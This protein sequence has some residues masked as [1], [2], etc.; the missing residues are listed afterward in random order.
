MSLAFEE[1]KLL[2]LQD[3]WDESQESMIEALQLLLGVAEMKT[4]NFNRLML[5]DHENH[6]RSS[7][8]SLFSDI[9]SSR[10]KLMFDCYDED[11]RDNVS[12]D[13]TETLYTADE[14][15]EVRIDRFIQKHNSII[16]KF[17]FIFFSRAMKNIFQFMVTLNVRNR[18]VHVQY[19]WPWVFVIQMNIFVDLLWKFLWIY[20]V[21][22]SRNLTNGNQI[23]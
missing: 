22:V 20:H 17:L 10:E 12:D 21:V 13:K 16:Y 6:L 5:L 18:F 8:E 4:K 2:L 23:H 14:N 11:D 15:Y 7:T 3:T 19:R 1:L 9:G